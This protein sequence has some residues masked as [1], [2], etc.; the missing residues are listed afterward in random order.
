[1]IRTPQRRLEASTREPPRR[2]RGTAADPT[3]W[4]NRTTMQFPTILLP[5]LLSIHRAAEATPYYD[6]D[7]YMKR[8]CLV[9]T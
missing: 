4:L 7:G 3:S 8:N 2:T 1:M 5:W 6:I 9:V